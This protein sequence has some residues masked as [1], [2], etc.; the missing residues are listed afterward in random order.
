MSTI[1]AITSK[2]M[3]AIELNASYLGVSSL[4]LMENA[5]R[6]ISSAIRERLTK[7][8]ITIFAGKGNNGGDALVAARYLEGFNVNVFLLGHARDIKTKETK[9]NWNKLK[10]TGTPLMEVHSTGDLDTDSIESSDIIIDAIFG[11]GVHGKIR[12]PAATMIDL[13]NASSA[14]VISVDVPSGMNPDTGMGDKMVNSDLILTFHKMKGGLVK[15]PNVK[16]VDIG[17]PK[18]AELFAGPGNLRSL[19]PRD[20]KS[21]KGDNGRILVIGGGLYSGA[22]ALAALAALRTGSDIVT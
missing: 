22:P 13:I 10:N 18:D 5:G 6:A 12:E 7:A 19:S 14:F 21:H 1:E 17:I 11:T 15:A 20:E 3:S 16:V 4:E 2:E 8:N 9:T